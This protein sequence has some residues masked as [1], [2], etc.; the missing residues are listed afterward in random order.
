MWGG[1]GPYANVLVTHKHR[2]TVGYKF[3]QAPYNV[4][5]SNAGFRRVLFYKFRNMHH[6]VKSREWDG[7]IVLQ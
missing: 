2:A 1:G 7:E 4:A 3:V 6:V 5:M